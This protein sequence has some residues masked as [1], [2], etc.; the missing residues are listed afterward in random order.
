MTND[1][2]ELL[3]DRLG[4][5]SPPPGDLTAVRR[6]G[7]RL[8]RRRQMGAGGAALATVAA[9]TAVVLVLGGGG[10]DP[11]D[12]RGLDPVGQLDFSHGLRAYAD[13]GYVIHLGGR[14]FPADRLEALD[15]DATATPYGVLYYDDGAPM[16]LGEDGRS[17]AIEPGAETTSETASA[18]VDSKHPWVA[19]SARLDGR[20]TIV[21][22]DLE[23]GSSVGTLDVGDHDDVAIDALDGGVVFFRDATARTWAWDTATGDEAQV[24]GPPSEECGDARACAEMVVADVRNGV[25]LYEGE[26]PTGPGA[27]GYRLVEGAIDAT[28]TYDGRHIVSWSNE[29]ESTDR[30]APIVLDQQATFYAVDTDGS[31]L[32]ASL[33]DPVMVYDCEVPSGACTELGPLTT[34]GGDPAFI[35]VDM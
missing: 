32:A 8:R 19:Y 12:D 22:R 21:V 14:E 25:L 34:R 5:L 33:G 30:S 27:A 11:R 7:R 6:D 17:V 13:P 31:I 18:K 35:G 16:L 1:L 15:T 3:H 29:L 23:D 24:D 28:L 2:R 20:P 4:R 10:T 26:R 9:G